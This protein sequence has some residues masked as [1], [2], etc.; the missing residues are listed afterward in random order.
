MFGTAGT[1]ESSLCACIRLNLGVKTDLDI[2]SDWA[3]CLVLCHI[4]DRLGTREGSVLYYLFQTVF[5][6][7]D[8]LHDFI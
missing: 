2:W 5:R 1:L 6:A 4:W 3:S 8:H 7:N